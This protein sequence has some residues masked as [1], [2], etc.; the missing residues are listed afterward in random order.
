VEDC[1]QVLVTAAVETDVPAGL[2]ER[3][4]TFA[5]ALGEVTR[6]A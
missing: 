4:T 3:G 1:E 6:V 5:V 2:R